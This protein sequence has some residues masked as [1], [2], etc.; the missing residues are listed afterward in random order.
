M[1]EVLAPPK[2]Q[3]SVA[4]QVAEAEAAHRK[5]DAALAVSLVLLV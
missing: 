2:P 5:A 3:L 4:E 1:Q